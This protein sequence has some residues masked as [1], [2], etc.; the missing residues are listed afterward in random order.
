MV[1]ISR[2]FLMLAIWSYLPNKPEDGELE[3]SAGTLRRQRRPRGPR[4]QAE[5]FTS[6]K[7]HHEAF[8]WQ[9][10]GARLADPPLS[11]KTWRQKSTLQGSKSSQKRL[12]VISH[13]ISHSFSQRARESLIK[14]N[15]MTIHPNPGPRNRDKTEEGKMRRRER[16]KEKR[17][18]KRKQKEEEKFK[19]L[20][21][22]TWN[23]QR[24]SLDTR[25]K[26]KTKSV[27]EYASKSNW[28]VVLLSEV[29]ATYREGDCMVG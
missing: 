25:N 27:A 18:E 13:S 22:A 9:R 8:F 20:R 15:L 5:R 16:R 6:A 2:I 14:F 11:L 4:K 28:D 24:M 10:R 21:V 23:V 19:F 3:V 29:R 17:K 12:G 26:R 7:K 1:N